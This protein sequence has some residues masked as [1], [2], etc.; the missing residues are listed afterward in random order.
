MDRQLGLHKNMDDWLENRTQLKDIP[1]DCELAAVE[2]MQ[3]LHAYHAI[4][5]TMIRQCK[6]RLYWPNMRADLQ[7]LYQECQQ[8]VKNK[9]SKCKPRVEV[10]PGQLF[11]HFS[12]E[13]V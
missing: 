1:A 13:K 9:A 3:I 10:H 8:G 7:K 6:T 5:D 12:Q 4:D 2:I 11:D